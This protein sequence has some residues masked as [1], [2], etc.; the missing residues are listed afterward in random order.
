MREI[1]GKIDQSLPPPP[2][3]VVGRE[4]LFE[5]AR[6]DS[7][8]GST[9]IWVCSALIRAATRWISR[10]RTFGHLARRSAGVC[11]LCGFVAVLTLHSDARIARLLERGPCGGL[12]ARKSE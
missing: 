9:P 8:L 4:T 3:E 12:T 2:G 1:V 10:P 5:S 7:R 11:R 6:H